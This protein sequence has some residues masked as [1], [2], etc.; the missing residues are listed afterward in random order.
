M[1]IFFQ[2][3]FLF[4]V[5]KLFLEGAMVKK[6]T[7][8][9]PIYK[10]NHFISHL[11][12]MLEE[13]WRT[14]NRNEI[15][16][17]EM[18]LVND[19]PHEK[20]EIK[21][22]WI[23]NISLIEIS[24]KKNCGIHYSRVQGLLRSSGDYI[25][26]LD[27]D[28]EISPIYIR[29]QMEALGQADAIICNGKNLSNLIYRTPEDLRKAID[30][31]EY[32]RGSNQIAS[33]G[34][35]LLRKSA[36]PEEWINNILLKNGA[37]DYFLWMLMFIKNR[38]V[39]IHNKVLY[40]HLTSDVNTSKN[41]D[42][43]DNSVFEMTS[44]MRKLEYLTEIEEKQIQKIRN[45]LRKWEPLSDEKYKKEMAHKQ[46]LETWMTLRD[47][48]ITVDM[49]LTK[50][51]IKRVAIYGCGMLGKHLYYELKESDITVV[52]MLDRNRMVNISGIK[53]IAPDELTEKVDAIIITPMMEYDKICEYLRQWHKCCMMSIETV[54]YNAD[55]KLM[56]E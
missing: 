1:I 23:Q 14:L 2:T 22:Q 52:C 25:L 40:W 47:R 50:M 41:V 51:G 3:S 56:M 32:R 26:F 16:D 54:I 34:Q 15:V 13:N 38:K 49:F 20:L 24:N 27:Q 11:V 12:H 48:K 30:K 5:R 35:V 46:I 9:I 36:I 33:P 42:E 44:K 31:E 45:D 19:F 55:Y 28:D 37:D 4:I 7:V 39:K 21:E 18:I 8:I 43:M 6:V 17:I 29:E 10:G 53:A